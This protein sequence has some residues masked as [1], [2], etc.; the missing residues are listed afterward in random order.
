MRHDPSL[1]R[2][3]IAIIGIHLLLSLPGL[4]V[5]YFNMDE[6][7]NATFA[8]FINNGELDLAHYL[9]DT[10]LLTHYLYAWLYRFID[11]D[12]LVPMHVLHTLWKSGTILALYWAGKRLSDR[13]TGLW[14]ALFYAVFSF[15]Y[16][17]KDFH[18]PTAESF[19]LLPAVLAAGFA[20][21][22]VNQRQAGAFLLAGMLTAVA[23]MFKA[24]AGVLWVALNLLVLAGKAGRVRFLVA[25][26]AGFLIAL[27]FPAV[28]VTPFGRGFSL[29]FEKLSETN[30]VYI[31]QFDDFSF[32]Y[33]GIKFV[34]RSAL[35]FGSMLAMSVFAAYNLRALFRLH[36]RGRE[37]WQK[38]LCLLAWFFLTWV[39]VA[40]GK[41]VF[42]HY[43]VFTL[44]PLALLAGVGI[45][46][47]D[48]RA[49]GQ[50][51][52]PI[53]GGLQFFGFVR[54]HIIHF[55]WFPPLLGFGD[56]ALNHSTHPPDLAGIIS[57]IRVHTDKHERIYVWGG[58]PQ[59]YFLSGRL[60]AATF[61]WSDALAGTHPGSP[62][63]EYIRATGR[64]LSMQEIFLKD[65]QARV[66][67]DDIVAADAPTAAINRIDEFEL[68]TVRELLE[69]I[70]N[71]YWQR[72]FSDFFKHPPVLFID[73]QPTNIRGFGH[74]PISNYELLKRFVKDNYELADEV[75]GMVVY[76][77]KEVVSSEL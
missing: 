43:Y 42:Y 7:T 37:L 44:A 11:S 1:C 6:A 9:G 45:R 66:F 51:W 15:A 8:R 34:S 65:F 24:P 33:W 3:L 31:Q 55:L 54:R 23:T 10:Y 56:A 63:M 52:F 38:I 14:A 4:W 19:S 35:V 26:N 50:R 12:S 61:F 25:L 40:I 69:R 57:Y 28:M 13:R 68:F 71:P 16:M 64:N 59:V 47:F 2:K 29:I 22:G 67:Q 20:F 70:D 62:A 5:P 48:L 27:L 46:Q 53:T 49:L 75:D 76:R 72:V 39:A 32:L 73:T 17:S 21:R 30:L 58:V 74:F 60:P 18:A 36:R 41:R 77:L